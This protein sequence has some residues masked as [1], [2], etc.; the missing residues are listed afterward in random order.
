MRTYG[1][2]QYDQLDIYEENGK[3][4]SIKAEKGGT[5]TNY[6]WTNNLSIAGNSALTFS[7]SYDANKGI[8]IASITIDAT[9]LLVSYDRY[10]TTCQESTE[11][12]MVET[13][14]PA[15]KMLIGGEI[16]ILVGEQLY[17]VQGV[18]V[19]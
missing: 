5:L 15:R 10:I 2:T 7:S 9:G 13:D 11:V 6:E 4:A 1:G 14:A 17:N 16:Y 3:L 18:R 8:G 19:R 12:V